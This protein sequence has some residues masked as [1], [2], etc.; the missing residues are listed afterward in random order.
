[1]SASEGASMG[2]RGAERAVRYGWEEMLT[3][4]GSAEELME[5]GSTGL[6]T[7]S[8]WAPER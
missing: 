1:M 3:S 6:E 8:P 5:W 2:T 7:K 4:S